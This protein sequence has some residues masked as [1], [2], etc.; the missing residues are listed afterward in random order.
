MEAEADTKLVAGR[1]RKARAH[2]ASPR[3]APEFPGCRPITI[4]RDEVDT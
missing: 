1:R 4:R 2:P 3:E